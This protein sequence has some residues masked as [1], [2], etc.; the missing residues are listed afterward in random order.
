MGSPPPDKAGAAG[1]LEGTGYELGAGVGITFFG[2]TLSVIY[3]NTIRLPAGL[4]AD[5]QTSAALFIGDT[6]VAA[7][8]IGSDGAALAEAGRAAFADANAIVMLTAASLITILAVGVFADLRNCQE[9]AEQPAL[10]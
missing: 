9:P 8:R 10:H 4:P 1:S 6:M 3:S 7:D 2:V 5:V